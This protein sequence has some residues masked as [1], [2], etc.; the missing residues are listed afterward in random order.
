[1]AFNSTNTTRTTNQS[2]TT[3][4][5]NNIWLD[6]IM[7]R[8]PTTTTNNSYSIGNGQGMFPSGKPTYSASGMG[9]MR[10]SNLAGMPSMDQWQGGLMND[11]N[12]QNNLNKVNFER[13]EK[14]ANM[15]LGLG[16]EGLSSFKDP[17][18]NGQAFFD[19]ARAFQKKGY[20]EAGVAG[21]KLNAQMDAAS[22]QQQRGH[23][24]AL[25][26]YSQG[27][28]K[29]GQGTDKIA[30]AMSAAAARRSSD[31]SDQIANQYGGA[32]PGS[33]SQLEDAYRSNRR[34][35]SDTVFS[36][37]SQIQNQANQMQAQMLAGKG[38][39]AATLADS[40]ASFKATAAQ[41]GFGAAQSKN[42]FNKLG[43]QI[44][45]GNAAFQFQNNEAFMGAALNVGR[46]YAD[47]VRNNPVMGV[48][49][50]PTLMAM[51]E[52]SKQYGF[53]N[54]LLMHPDNR[55][56]TGPSSALGGLG[57]I[58]GG[59]GMEALRQQK[60]RQYAEQQGFNYA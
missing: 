1:M 38:S 37:V 45:M 11:L 48:A 15:F 23:Q 58:G 7:G 26:M 43:A 3:G 25:G 50:M 36:G 13:N 21:D 17:S 4:A 9:G 30:S 6:S 57:E 53:S 35:L 60:N 39:L 49:I 28:N 24:E 46:G 40:S 22:K 42:E 41:A 19:E 59:A 10:Q 55:F 12:L 5:N 32:F 34:D 20:D 44:A 47:M 33:E 54:N 18:K 14:A 8:G 51:G 31:Q 52:L 27:I 16:Q 56:Q 2:N 29:V